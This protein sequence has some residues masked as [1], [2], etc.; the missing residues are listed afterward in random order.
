MLQNDLAF[1]RPLQ[2]Q[3]HPARA[4]GART[5]ARTH[6]RTLGCS[7]ARAQQDACRRLNWPAT[8]DR[9]TQLTH[10]PFPRI[11]TPFP[12]DVLPQHSDRGT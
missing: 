6:A 5:R 2:P 10:A 12:D 3:P 4:H 7:H 11:T 1:L 8:A 9:D